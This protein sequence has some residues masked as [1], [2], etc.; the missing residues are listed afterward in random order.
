MVEKDLKADY[1]VNKC[2]MLLRKKNHYKTSVSD[3]LYLTCI[4][5][6]RKTRM[7]DDL[8]RKLLALQQDAIVS[9][10]CQYENRTVFGILKK[11]VPD[12]TDTEPDIKKINFTRVSSDKYLYEATADQCLDMAKFRVLFTCSGVAGSFS[13]SALR[14]YDVALALIPRMLSRKKKKWKA[15]EKLPDAKI[16]TSFPDEYDKYIKEKVTL[17]G[18]IPQNRKQCELL[19][20][21]A[22]AQKDNIKIKTASDKILQ[23]FREVINPPGKIYSGL[24]LLD[25]VTWTMIAWIV[26]PQK[27]INAPD[28]L[29]EYL[30]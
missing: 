28:V 13:E 10:L 5:W 20:G 17:Q 7:N 19:R 2:E 3:Y 27:G 9:I 6:L 22:L 14:L 30:G 29:R 18:T 21:L 23:Y 26:L 8:V 12:M 1:Y 15:L 4:N 11:L 25:E 16:K 24:S